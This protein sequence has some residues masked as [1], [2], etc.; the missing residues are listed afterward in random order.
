MQDKVG[1]SSVVELGDRSK[2][3]AS[4]WPNNIMPNL[5]QGTDVSNFLPVYAPEM[6]ADDTL[7]PDD[8]VLLRQLY[9]YFYQ[10]DEFV[11][12][13]IDIHTEIPLS[14]FLLLPPRAETQAGKNLVKQAMHV[15]DAVKEDLDLFEV[16]LEASHEY[17]L[18]GECFLYHELDEDS[19]VWTNIL[20]LD[21]DFV[22]TDRPQLGS[23]KKIYIRPSEDVME[24]MQSHSNMDTE[25]KDFIDLLPS[26][27]QMQL[28]EEGR[29]ELNTDPSKGSFVYHL[30]RRRN[31]K[32]DRGISILNR[33]LRT[34]IYRD[35]LRSVQSLISQRN[36][37]NI[38]LVYSE[39]AETGLGDD[40]FE[41]F[42]EQVDVALNTPDFAIVTD[43]P[44]VW[45]V[46]SG[47]ARMIDLTSEYEQTSERM[48]VGLGL[49]REILKGEG[50]YSSARIS[51]EIL[52]LRYQLFIHRVARYLENHV[53]KPIAIMKG[54]SE[55][56][57]EEDDDSKFSFKK[58][59]FPKVSFSRTTLYDS[60]SV[61]EMLWNIYLKGSLSIRTI[62]EV[63]SLDYDIEMDKLA[64]DMFGPADASFNEAVVGVMQG[65]PDRLLDETNIVDVIIQKLQLAGVPI[66]KKEMEPEPEEGEEGEPGG[67]PFGDDEPPSPFGDEPPEV[68]EE[69]GGED[70]ID[71]L[72]EG[73]PGPAEPLPGPPE[74][75]EETPLPE[76]GPEELP[77]EPES[78]KVEEPPV[79][80]EEAPGFEE[81]EVPPPEA[82]YEEEGKKKKKKK[83]VPPP[84]APYDE[85]EDET[86]EL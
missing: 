43:F 41:T 80:E 66:E 24:A 9:R 16:L 52:N 12:Q 64:A 76:T 63:V 58:Y 65:V 25:V 49:T 37:A 75:F 31:S 50:M 51:I 74:D 62:M 14:R 55:E 53:F 44:V 11:G 6:G 13:A 35:Q 26:E 54:Y 81:E 4:Y 67:S 30:T 21:P 60:E 34:L 39:T 20:I 29:I 33:V 85:E 84:E 38:H 69:P 82:P 5:G 7:V 19:Q 48:L 3:A 1:S 10:W 71:P 32:E 77:E 73:P 47:G 27:W 17:W 23:D 36:L 79:V 46:I 40:N 18:N 86:F 61:F 45:Q 83:K 28:K 56:I 22:E 57:V 68:P 15:Y 59:L 42:R 78:L 70:L 2:V 8:P 72:E